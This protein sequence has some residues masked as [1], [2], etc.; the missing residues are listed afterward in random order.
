MLALLCGVA[1]YG[2]SACETPAAPPATEVTRVI[3]QGQ[4]LPDEIKR[5]DLLTFAR[6]VI[7]VRQTGLAGGSSGRAL[8]VIDGDPYRMGLTIDRNGPVELVYKLPAPTTFDRFAVPGVK[9]WPGNVTFVGSLTVSGSLESF[10]DGYQT[11]A[12]FDFEP[13]GP[14]ETE[15]EE[16]PTV[17]TP[18]RWVKL[19]FE[20]GMNIEPDHV[21]RTNLRFTELVGNGTQELRPLSTAFDGVWDLRLTERI[22][23]S[24]QPLELHQD[25]ATIW[26]CAGYV[27]LQGTVN[28]AIAR[29]TGEDTRN[30]RP[31]A[32]IFVADEDGTIHANVSSNRGRFG[33]RTAVDDPDTT[34]APCSEAPPEVVACGA[35]VYVNFDV[36]SAVIRPESE[37]VL[38]DLYQQL[39]DE[40]AQGITVVGHTSTEGS[41]EYNQDL[42]ERRA[43]AVV[44]DL[45]SRG[46]AA[47][48]VTERVNDFETLFFE[49]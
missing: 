22:E 38:A 19:N 17:T 6:G 20:G 4:P 46:F 44:D 11:L 8:R 9:E 41:L 26:G 39:V 2:V 1:A 43:Q 49:N 5:P 27:E 36:N 18:V 47:A 34:S 3:E 42:S 13:L 35:N 29:A 31:A 48:N 21:D 32:F 7:F 16:T 37:Q 10:E 23:V 40:Q 24:G 30:G 28:G 12:S 14:G 25:G 15:T 45:I 33:A